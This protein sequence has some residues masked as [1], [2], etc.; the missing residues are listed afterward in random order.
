MDNTTLNNITG[1]CKRLLNQVFISSGLEQLMIIARYCS[2]SQ[3]ISQVEELSENYHFMLTFLAEGGKDEK[4]EQTQEKICRKA[5]E[6]LR[7]AHRDIRLQG[8]HTLYSKAFHELRNLYG[9]EP[10]EVLLQKWR[11]NL[12]PDE[13]LSI[14]DHVFSLIWTSPI[15]TQKETAQ[16]YEFISR[17]TDFVKIH[18]IG[19]V[20]QSLWDYFDKEKLSLLFLFT[21][22]ESQKVN[23]LTIAALVMLAEKY[24]KELLLYPQLV[25]QYQNSNVIKYIPVVLKEKLLMLQTLVA[26]KKEQDDMAG[27]S[28]NMSQE[29]MEKLMNK[30]MELL[31]YMVAKGLDINLGNRTEMWY[32]CDFLRDNISHWW[33]PFEK[34]S[35]VIEGMVLDKDGNFNKQAYKILDLPSECDIDRY[36][37]FSFMAN[38][39]YKNT[40]IEHMTE[41]LDMINLPGEEQMVPYVDYMKMTIQNLYRIFAHSPIKSEVD[42]PFKFSHNY[43]INP[44]FKDH[45]TEENV[46]NLCTEMMEAQ[47]LDAPVTWINKLAETAGTSQAMLKLKGDCL[48]RNHKYAEA[49]ES[50]TQILFFQDDDEWALNMLQECYEKTGRKE[51][52]LE[53]IQRLI[54][55]RPDKTN[56]MTIAAIV[57]IE[58][59]RYE[60]ALKHLFHLDY[61]K[62]DNVVYKTCIETCAL[63]LKKFDLA[64]RYNQTILG[65]KDYKDRYNEYMMAGHVHFAMGD[66][67]EA[68]ACYKEFK[69]QAEELN[70]TENR[71]IDP[72]KEFLTS[73]K[74]LTELGISQTDIRL[75]LD[76]MSL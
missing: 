40:F 21:D 5:Q 26:I 13:Q 11:E 12:L 35:P 1:S 54:E 61:I 53:I 46:L 19:A 76:M 57:L 24:E 39:K 75:M 51:K 8:E 60:E 22:T 25:E 74:I 23:T 64:L 7:V 68:L 10:E 48:F 58:M 17:Q 72:E 16:W 28:L 49:I 31:R 38:T 32:K 36:S 15:W 44:I 9:P 41:T 66:W 27:F 62:A 73:S 45:F 29:D 63:H 42:N 20:I 33:I 37:M 59:E 71:K 3:I 65:Y 6:I 30:K 50:L 55:I 67:K 4:R 70:T 14:Q 34:S 18:F 69:A 56:Y 52:Q 43:W 2:D 47:I